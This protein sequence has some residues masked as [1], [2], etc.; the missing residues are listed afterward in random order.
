MIEIE[1]VVDTYKIDHF[2]SLPDVIKCRL[3]EEDED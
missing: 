1:L 3:A 2:Y